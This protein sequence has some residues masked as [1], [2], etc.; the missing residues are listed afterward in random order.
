MKL[1]SS[2]LSNFAWLF[3][4]YS[5]TFQHQTFQLLVFSNYAFQLHVSPYNLTTYGINHQKLRSKIHH[6][7]LFLK[8]S[9]DIPKFTFSPEKVCNQSVR[10]EHFR[11]RE[12][13]RGFSIFHISLR[14]LKP[15]ENIHKLKFLPFQQ[16]HFLPFM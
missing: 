8:L 14:E 3:P 9:H 16:A 12:C 5:E 7:A 4:T 13:V 15:P 2:V 6:R 10:S 1:E 11:V